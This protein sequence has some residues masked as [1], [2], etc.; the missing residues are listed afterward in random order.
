MDAR[1]E[2][3]AAL[4][5]GMAAVAPLGSKHTAAPPD[6]APPD[7]AT[8]KRRGAQGV[9]SCVTAMSAIS[10]PGILLASSGGQAD[11]IPGT[12]GFHEVGG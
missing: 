3:E 7:T 4:G 8:T 2:V 9:T 5:A 12:A 1:V 6:G 10:S 11:P